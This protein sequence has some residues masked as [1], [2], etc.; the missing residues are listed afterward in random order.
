[1]CAMCVCV[2]VFLYVFNFVYYLFNQYILLLY[3]PQ[4]HLYYYQYQ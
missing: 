4:E 1:M 3:P 2:C